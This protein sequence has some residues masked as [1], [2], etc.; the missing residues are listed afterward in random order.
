MVDLSVLCR[1]EREREEGRRKLKLFSFLFLS[2]PLSFPPPT[3][4][5]S[6]RGLHTFKGHAYL[7]PF[8]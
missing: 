2:P 1:K 6:F 5:S 3:H 4:C 8:I 7:L